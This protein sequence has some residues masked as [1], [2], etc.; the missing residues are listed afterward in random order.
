MFYIYKFYKYVYILHKITNVPVRY[1]FR[2]FGNIS[3]LTWRTFS[4]VL[5]TWYCFSKFQMF[6]FGRLCLTLSR[7][8]PKK[9]A[10]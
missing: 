2:W 10:G 8:S 7:L 4:I 1:C 5:S 3:W 6:S 9:M